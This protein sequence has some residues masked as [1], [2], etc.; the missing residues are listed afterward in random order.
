MPARRAVS[1][2]LVGAV[3]GALLTLSATL[4]ASIWTKD[5]A[6]P[7]I[8]TLGGGAA[9]AAAVRA[10]AAT[11]DGTTATGTAVGTT[12]TSTATPAWG[13]LRP[14]ACDGPAF[15]T[16]GVHVP[17]R[18]PASIGNFLGR[19]VQLLRT[20]SDRKGLAFLANDLN[21][22]GRAVEL[23][24]WRGEFAEHNLNK[25][26]GAKY[27]LVDLWTSRD[28]DCVNGNESFCVYGGNESRSY[29]KMVTGLRM[30]RGGARFAGRYEM[31]QNS[32]LEAATLFPD[33]HFDW[34]YL[35]A[36]HTYAEAKADLDAW[37]PK[38]RLGGLISGHDY[39]FQHQAIGDGYV[40]G[41][42]DA[43]DEFAA[44]RHLRVYQTSE[45]YLPS[46]LR[47]RS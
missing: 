13:R 7:S 3:V 25:W 11:A 37:Y 15:A 4:G 32:T 16:G 17:I 14:T 31:V 38:V 6:R 8:T 2:A 26:R 30:Q 42:R 24:V 5:A 34:L 43:V 18:G 20:L 39:Q 27:V 29:D 22:T 41:V 21:L 45:P 47:T 1:S 46:F 19:P 35:D 40:F 10:A 36:T 12:A 9:A 28:T 23:G 44:R 33:G